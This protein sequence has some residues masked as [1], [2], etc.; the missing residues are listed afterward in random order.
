MLSSLAP[1][2]ACDVISL[3][4]LD[5][6]TVAEFASAV[7]DRLRHDPCDLVVGYSLGGRIALEICA[8]DLECAPRLLL[9][10][11]HPGITDATV[12]Q[13][14]A[15]EDDRRAILLRTLGVASFIEHWY[16]ADLFASFRQHASFATT[17]ARRVKG[18]ADFWAGVVAGCS[19]GRS[20]SRWAALAAHASNIT[21]AAGGTDARYAAILR[22]SQ[23][24]IPSLRTHLIPDA[25]HVLPLEAPS[26]CARLIE[27]MLRQTV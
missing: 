8:G 25:G 21:M 24:S 19:P 16:E 9:L 23:A 12:R 10:S 5:C 4:A 7:R 14:R 27:A 3:R 2:I 1:S 22:E 17:K 26:A 6:R 15:A 13:A 11:T 20:E 18:D